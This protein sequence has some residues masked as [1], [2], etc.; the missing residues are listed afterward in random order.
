[1]LISVLLIIVAISVLVI[2]HEWG[3]FYTA[4]KFGMKVEEFGIG[5]LWRVYSIER[6]GVI[7]SFNAIP[8]GGFVKIYGENATRDD[9]EGFASYP[10]WQRIVVVGAGVVMNFVLT[11]LL[12]IVV[13][14]TDPD[15]S[16][17]GA[18]WNAVVVS[19]EGIGLI[20]VAL[21][22]VFRQGSLSSDIVGPLGVAAHITESTVAFDIIQ[23]IR[24]M[25][26]LSLSLAVFNLLPFPALD[27]GR[28]FFFAIEAVKGRPM[29][30]HTEATIHFIGF[31]VL[32]ALIILVTI[33]DIIN[34]M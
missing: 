22:E 15:Y 7:Y 33:K 12:L 32:I 3:H 9:P 10:L 25:A 31:L 14:L 19:V 26:S 23:Y 2:I 20:F 5:F 11:V 34:I 18:V 17:F 29:N 24:L 30:K 28:L 6:N 27:G 16:I 8:L 4:R 1:M 21:Y 13:F